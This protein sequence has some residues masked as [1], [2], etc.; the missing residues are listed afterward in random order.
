VSATEFRLQGKDLT[1]VAELE[2]QLKALA[3][4]SPKLPLLVIGA[5]QSHFGV[6]IMVV[7][8]C[9]KAGLT[10]IKIDGAPEH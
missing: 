1:A 9:R 4:R 3:K 2:V 10:D 5:D 8:A 7:D 6:A